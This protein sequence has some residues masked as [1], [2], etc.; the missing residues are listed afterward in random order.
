M[1]ESGSFLGCQVLVSVTRGKIESGLQSEISVSVTEKKTDPA[2]F[3]Q[4][5]TD[6]AHFLSFGK[7]DSD[8]YS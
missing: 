3:R 6:P 8:M 7:N 4:N 5:C 1:T 2:H